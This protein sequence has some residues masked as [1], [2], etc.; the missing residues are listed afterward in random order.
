MDPNINVIISEGHLDDSSGNMKC[1][2]PRPDWDFE[3]SWQ[4]KSKLKLLVK[5]SS[6]VSK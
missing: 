2:S 6:Y 5:Q 1:R 4:C 3:E